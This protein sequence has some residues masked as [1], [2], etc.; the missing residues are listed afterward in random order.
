[1][2]NKFPKDSKV[3]VLFEVESGNELDLKYATNVE[4]KDYTTINK[5]YSYSSFE[6]KSIDYIDNYWKI[7]LGW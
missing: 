6:I 2:N 4:F 5:K 3:K 1:M 7:E